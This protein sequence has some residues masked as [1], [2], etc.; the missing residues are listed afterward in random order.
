MAKRQDSVTP[1]AARASIK[2]AAD[3]APVTAGGKWRTAARVAEKATDTRAAGP[4]GKKVVKK[5][6]AAT[7]TASS[8]T[9]TN[10]KP[11]ITAQE[12]ERLVRE[13]AFLLSMNRNPCDGS[14]SVDW[15]QAEAVIGM[16]FDIRD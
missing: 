1:S 8:A 15:R 9:V 14:P 11:A 6:T 10:A 13:A 12:R 7:R 5:K 3:K 4:V 16:I 2:K